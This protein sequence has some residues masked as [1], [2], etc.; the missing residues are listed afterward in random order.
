MSKKTTTRR[1]IKAALPA[2]ASDISTP[3]VKAIL[4]D[5]DGTLVQMRPAGRMLVLNETLADFGLPPMTT[6]EMVERFWFT[7]ERYAMIDSWG[8]ERVDFWK[9]FDCEKILEMQMNHTYAY[10]DVGDVMLALRARSLQLGI[11]SNSAHI[12]LNLKLKLLDEQVDR[13]N[14]DVVVSC[15]DDVRH[16]KPYPDGV[17]LA[18]AYLNVRPEEA[19]LIGDSLDDVG[20]G[21]NAGV[22]VLI[23]NRGQLPTL[24]E[25]LNGAAPTF[26]VINSLHDL[27]QML[28]LT[29]PQHAGQAA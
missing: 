10:E 26:G 15:N 12:S 11:V 14:F 18:L 9:A 7:A 1:Q 8:I 2:T 20:A 22:R 25:K 13:H 17:E 19:V 5:M 3:T 24:H 28:G 29:E 21:N 23:V 6:M 16:T 4:F 27:P